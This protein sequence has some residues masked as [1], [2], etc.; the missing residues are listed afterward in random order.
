MDVENVGANGPGNKAKVFGMQEGTTDFITNRYRVDIQYRGTAGAP[1]NCITF[2]A[3]YGSGSDL[4]VRYELTDD[5]KPDSPMVQ[6]P[7][8]ITNACRLSLR[9]FGDD[10]RPRGTGWQREFSPAPEPKH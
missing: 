7:Q 2:R 8:A 10:G 1:P 6:G 3:L 5:V 4:D 9:Y